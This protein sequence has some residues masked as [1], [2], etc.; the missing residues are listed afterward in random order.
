M[1][2]KVIRVLKESQYI[3]L[4]V[5]PEKGLKKMGKVTKI[6]NKYKTLN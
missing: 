3:D 2:V 5:Y 6:K 1:N 4:S